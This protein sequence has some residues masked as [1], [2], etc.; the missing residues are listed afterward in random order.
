MFEREPNRVIKQLP[1]AARA[2]RVGRASLA[3]PDL[4]LDPDNP[5]RQRE[6]QTFDGNFVPPNL[7]YNEVP[8]CL[9]IGPYP[10]SRED[11]RLMKE[12]GVTGVLNVQTDFD[13]QCRMINW[14]HMLQAYESEQLQVL[15]PR[16][17][18]SRNGYSRNGHSRNVASSA[19]TRA[20][21]SCLRGRHWAFPAGL[22]MYIY[23]YIYIYYTCIYVCYTYM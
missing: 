12:R 14:A 13:H 4:D 7:S 6:W 23:I 2:A 18:S 17:G 21:T 3:L 20:P 5:R 10:Q 22:C 9:A 11:V 1:G 19:S 15:P 16:N 8:P